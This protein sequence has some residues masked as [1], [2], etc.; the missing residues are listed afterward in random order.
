MNIVSPVLRRPSAQAPGAW[1]N[2]APPSPQPARGQRAGRGADAGAEAAQPGGRSPPPYR[3]P[4]GSTP[5]LADHS[6]DPTRPPTHT[7]HP[8]Y[9][10]VIVA[11]SP[12]AILRYGVLASQ[13]AQP[14][15][16]T[17]SR[18]VAA[19]SI[20]V[21]LQAGRPSLHVGGARSVA[22]P[23]VE[24]SPQASSSARSSSSPLLHFQKRS[25]LTSSTRE[26]RHGGASEP[27]CAHGEAKSSPRSRSFHPNV[28]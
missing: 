7:P 25:R 28:P 21:A 5:E 16:R 18:L 13:Q 17:L 15:A 2:I 22:A 27:A 23:H 3:L 26:A 14:Q 11:G 12:K 4:A 10:G 6:G 1:A 9:R 19:P 8:A 24:V 20:G